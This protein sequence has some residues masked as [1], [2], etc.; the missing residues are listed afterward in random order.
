MIIA[1]DLDGTLIDSAPDICAMAS[2][3]LRARNLPELVEDGPDALGVLLV[4]RHGQVSAI[5]RSTSSRS[6]PR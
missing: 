2:G 6:R 5:S 1:F 4:D 3:I